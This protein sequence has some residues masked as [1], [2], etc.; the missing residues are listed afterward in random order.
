MLRQKYLMPEPIPSNH[1]LCIS[2]W[3]T[4]VCHVHSD[5][6]TKKFLAM[7]IFSGW[8]WSSCE[9]CTAAFTK[10]N[11]CYWNLPHTSS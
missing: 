11:K 8:L 9:V 3:L 6:F 5:T 7:S 1:R 4:V 2:V 10:P